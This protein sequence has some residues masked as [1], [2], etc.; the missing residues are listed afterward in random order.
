[1]HVTKRY[2]HESRRDYALRIIK[3][4]IIRLDLEPGSMVSEN[5]LASE[6]GLSRGPVRE[7]LMELAKVKI[8]DI[9]PQRGSVISKVNYDLIEEACFLRETLETAVAERCCLQGLRPEHLS[10]LRENVKLQQFYLENHNRDRL[11]DLDDDFHRRLFSSANLTQVYILM[12]SMMVHFDRVR[13]MS[14]VAV[15]EIRFVEDHR[16]ILETIVKGDSEAAKQLVHSHLTRY[17]V[18]K[19]EIYAKYPQYLK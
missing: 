16:V 11:W 13:A 6:L 2:A 14:L 5:E 19:R 12:N 1:M 3:D 4:N 9:Y 17:Q 10:A 7:A 15:R 18:D 8:V